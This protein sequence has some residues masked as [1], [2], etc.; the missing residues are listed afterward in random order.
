MPGDTAGCAIGF[1]CFA[2]AVAS[3][4]TAARIPDGLDWSAFNKAPRR[5]LVCGGRRAS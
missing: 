4:V 3:R 5:G 1:N 2:D